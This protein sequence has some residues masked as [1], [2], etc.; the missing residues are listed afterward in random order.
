MRISLFLLLALISLL[1]PAALGQPSPRNRLTVKAVNRL[2]IARQNE[3]IELTA[4]ELAA[5]GEKD[6]TKIHVSDSAGKELLCQAV[7]MDYD[8]YHKPDI[9]IFQTDF[10]ANETK[11]FVITAGK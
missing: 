4:K 5:L 8:E 7:D 9:V 10:A 1:T 3:T 6:L 2:K 11:T